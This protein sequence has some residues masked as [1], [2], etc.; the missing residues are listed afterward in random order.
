[1]DGTDPL[2]VLGLRKGLLERAT[3]YARDVTAQVRR[4][5]LVRPTPC[6]RWDL[7]ELLWHVNESVVALRE[8]I[9][10]ECVFPEPLS[11]DPAE[12]HDVLRTF[13]RE[14]ALLLDA[15]DEPGYDSTVVVGRYPVRGMVLANTGALEIAVHGWDV[16]RSCDLPAVI[17]RDLAVDLLAVA[18]LVMPLPR[19]PQFGPEVV[20]PDWACASDRLVAFLGRRPVV[21]CREQGTDGGPAVTGACEDRFSETS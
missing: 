11:P 14:S 5:Q 9:E 3:R 4:P 10:Q 12:V 18:R 17:P 19:H 1:M 7:L 6:G 15:W 16:A 8:A 13:E 20:C 21:W 2:A